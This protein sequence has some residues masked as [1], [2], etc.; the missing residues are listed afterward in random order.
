M[1]K[2]RPVLASDCGG[3]RELIEDGKTGMLFPA[4]CPAALA[5]SA[6]LLSTTPEAWPELGSTAR[7][8]VEKTRTWPAIVANY[9][10]VYAEVAKRCIH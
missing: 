2:G 4:D 7:R 6:I 8:F 9:D 1:A 10:G 5:K 3:H